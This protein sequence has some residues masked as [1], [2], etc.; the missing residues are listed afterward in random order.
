MAGALSSLLEPHPQAPYNGRKNSCLPLCRHVSQIITQKKFVSLR[1]QTQNRS[2]GL[3]G[4]SQNSFLLAL[5]SL[6]R[7]F[8]TSRL[9]LS[10]AM[11]RHQLCSVMKMTCL[12][13][14]SIHLL[15]TK[16]TLL[17][18]VALL[19]PL[20]PCQILIDPSQRLLMRVRRHSTHATLSLLKIDS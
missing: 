9:D 8:H 18:I 20:T 10:L 4:W 13:T 16:K 17:R 12:N 11:I 14:T 3:C 5:R 1:F 7:I 6:L 19:K 2:G 15:L